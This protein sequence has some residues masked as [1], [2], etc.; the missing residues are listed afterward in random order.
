M[1]EDGNKKISFDWKSLAIKLG[2]LAAT[3]LVVILIFNLFTGKKDNKSNDTKLADSNSEYITNINMMKDAAFEYFTSDKLPENVGN[4]RKVTLAEMIDQKLLIDFTDNGKTCDLNSSY[5]QATKTADENYAL[6]VGLKCEKKADFIVTTIEKKDVVNNTTNNSTN[7]NKPN[8][9]ISKPN[10]N[11]SSNNNSSSNN[12][13]PT[14]TTTK[15]TIQLQGGCIFNCSTSDNNNNNNNN[16]KPTTPS[17]GKTRYYK[18]VKYSPWA[19]GKSYADNA[20][21]RYQTVTTADYCPITRKTYYSSGYITDNRGNYSYE[22][23]FK[24]LDPDNIAH[25]RLESKSYFTNNSA[26]SDYKAYINQ[27]YQ[28]LH[29]TGNQYKNEAYTSDPK[30][31]KA[32]SLKSSNFTFD[33]SKIYYSRVNDVYATT[34]TVNYKNHTGITPFYANS[35]NKYVYF[36]PVKFN[37]EIAYEDECRRDTSDNWTRYD[38]AFILNEREEKIWTHRTVDYTWS[39]NK[40]LSGWEYTGVYEDR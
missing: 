33:V 36:V 17:T 21:N 38:N 2:I 20:E 32:S 10:N 34:I 4:T 28:N 22:V 5:V 3:V 40:N 15:V 1:Y 29:M 14:T 13:K 8:T 12:Q 6:K 9:N 16:N 37:V 39:T 26:A 27:R 30:T 7:T 25:I 23:Q 35:I 19:K 24:D 18:L 31:M 11:G